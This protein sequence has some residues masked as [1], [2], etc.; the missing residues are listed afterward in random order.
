MPG[1]RNLKTDSMKSIG[2][3]SLGTL[4]Q[5]SFGDKFLLYDFENISTLQILVGGMSA[6]YLQGNC[7]L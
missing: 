1:L 7:H 3:K 2:M 6:A 5:F 4:H